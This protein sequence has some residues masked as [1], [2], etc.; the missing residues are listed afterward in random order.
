MRALKAAA[1]GAA[2]LFGTFASQADAAILIDFGDTAQPRGPYSEDGFDFTAQLVTSSNCTAGACAVVNGTGL[3]IGGH[4]SP[5][6]LQ[7]LDLDIL[8]ADGVT[9][10]SNK[11]FITNATSS[12][13]VSLASFA[14]AQGVTGITIARFNANGVGNGSVFIDNLMV[15]PLPAALPL[16]LSAVGGLFGFRWLKN[17]KATAPA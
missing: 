11:G 1:L 13:T 2:M 4:G 17:R 12:G 5:F 8:G 3:F 6:D 10:Q 14:N 7:S 9:I 15:T 16:L